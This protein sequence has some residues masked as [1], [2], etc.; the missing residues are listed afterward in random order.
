M[1]TIGKITEQIYRV[2]SGGNP[3]DDSEITKSEI[4]SLVS[5]SINKLLKS[6]YL[7]VN[8]KDGDYF[9]PHSMISTY[10]VGSI[11]TYET[12]KAR[13]KLPVVP[14]SLPRDMGVWSVSTSGDADQQYIPLQSG[15]YTLLS[16][17]D[18]L[19][20]L[21]NQV[22]YYVDGQYLIFTK[23]ITQSPYSCST[24]KVRLLTIDATTLDDYDIV[25]IP[26]DME[27]GVIKDVLQFL[28]VVPKVVDKVSDS[29]NQV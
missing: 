19:Q 3:S 25:Q 22:G 6:E 5:Q 7:G 4:K 29:N 18:V 10:N 11:S 1:T 28:G 23:D 24:L 15:Q 9:P 26:A 17:Q 8:R 12:V 21:D 2:Y 27:D 20:H 13:A 14:I 16:S